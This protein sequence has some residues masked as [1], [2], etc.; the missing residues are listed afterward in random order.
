ML[1]S[2]ALD[3]TKKM[4]K[5]GADIFAKSGPEKPSTNRNKIKTFLDGIPPGKVDTFQEHLTQQLKKMGK[6]KEK[7]I[8]RIVSLWTSQPPGSEKEQEILMLLN[9]TISRLDGKL[10]NLHKIKKENPVICFL[11]MAKI[12]YIS[13]KNEDIQ[14]ATDLWNTLNQ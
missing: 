5:A 7:A 8:A 6:K 9:H 11:L 14:A 13:P 12:G 1:V 10:A 4:R 2:R 3:D